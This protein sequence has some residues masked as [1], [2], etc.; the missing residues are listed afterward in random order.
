MKSTLAH[1]QLL[2][3]KQPLHRQLENNQPIRSRRNLV[4]WM[5]LVFFLSVCFYFG[6]SYRNLKSEC[7]KQVR[8][9]EYQLE[10][11]K[12]S[13]ETRLKSEEMMNHQLLNEKLQSVMKENEFDVQ[14]YLIIS[15]VSLGLVIIVL[16]I[17]ICFK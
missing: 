10:Q 3:L 2:G 6:L 17:V 16:S 4:M 15:S 9:L 14:K 8:S 12:M 13:E 5:S 7:I 1:R 11:C